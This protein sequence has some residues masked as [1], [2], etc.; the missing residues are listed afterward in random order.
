MAFSKGS[1]REQVRKRRKMASLYQSWY[2][3]TDG[4]LIPLAH[5]APPARVGQIAEMLV[6]SE[7]TPDQNDRMEIENRWRELA[8]SQF[9]M[10][11]RVSSLEKGVLFLE[12]RHSAFLAEEMSSAT[13]LLVERINS[14]LGRQV[15]T[16]VRFVPRG[17]SSSRR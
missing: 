4:A 7:M 11:C 8:G 2:G 6:R 17:R 14:K 9:A 10:M 5:D 16:A 3:E 12:I 1:Y 13:D 15:C